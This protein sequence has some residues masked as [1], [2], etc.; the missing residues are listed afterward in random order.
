MAGRSPATA[1]QAAAQPPTA[2]PLHSTP[3]P[4]HRQRLQQAAPLCCPAPAHC[5]PVGQAPAHCT[6]RL[7]QVRLKTRPFAP[8]P[9]YL[10]TYPSYTYPTKHS[11][12]APAP[13]QQATMALRL[14][15]RPMAARAA[16]PSRR[17]A[18]VVK[19]LSL[20]EA[21]DMV[22]TKSRGASAVS[23]TESDAWRI[24]NGLP[25][26]RW[27]TRARAR[28]GL[29]GQSA[30]VSEADAD[31]ANRRVRVRVFPQVATAFV[32]IFSPPTSTV[33]DFPM[34]AGF[35]GSTRH[36][37]HS[38]PF[39]AGVLRTAHFRLPRGTLRATFPSATRAPPLPRLAAPPSAP[40][41]LFQHAFLLPRFHHLRPN[42]TATAP[43]RSCRPRP[44]WRP[45]PQ[46]RPTP[47]AMCRTRSRAWC[48]ACAARP[49][50]SR[51]G[52]ARPR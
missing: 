10:H 27:A 30:A 49:P 35:S 13:V 28:P 22:R 12:Q 25:T 24:N 15:I 41:L 23:E 50:T 42:R 6:V 5:S 33:K 43:C 48:P 17:A 18:M 1:P 32:R 21:S 2:P 31:A 8:L 52:Q 38:R 44:R 26:P 4:S 36:N 20:K 14:S 40:S 37:K 11:I 39:Q 16:Q 29:G 7:L 45:R 3:N 19:A 51:S 46:T 34:N 9:S 47:L